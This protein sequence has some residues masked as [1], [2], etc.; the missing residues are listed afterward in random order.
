MNYNKPM[1]TKRNHRV[2][3]FDSQY[4]AQCM[5]ERVPSSYIDFAARVKVEDLRSRAIIDKLGRLSH[6]IQPVS[7]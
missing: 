2:F 3:S 4:N 7:G 5:P 1:K 6:A